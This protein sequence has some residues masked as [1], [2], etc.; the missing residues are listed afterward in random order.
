MDDAGLPEDVFTSG[1]TAEERGRL[2]GTSLRVYQYFAGLPEPLRVPDFLG[3][4]RSQGLS[5]PFPLPVGPFLLAPI[6]HRGEGVGNIYLA[7]EE[8][9]PEFSRED[10]ET[11]VLFASQAALV[12]ANARRH[13]DERRARADLEA[14][15]NT[16]PV[17]VLVF[18][19]LTGNPVSVNQEARRIIGDLH[20]PHR[21]AEELLDDLTVRRDDGREFS[22]QELSVAQ[23]L[24]AAVTV[25]AE[26]IVLTAPDGRSVTALINA[27]PIRGE[28]GAVETCVVTLQDMTPLEE[29]ERLRAEFLAMVSHELRTPLA[30]VKGSVANLLDP[31][32]SLS[33]AEALQFFRIID[34][35]T[36][37]MRSLI[38]DLLDVARIETGTLSVSPEPTELAVLA[39]EAADAFRVGGHK[40]SLRIDLQPDLPWVMADRSRVV[41]V[42]GNLLSNAARHSP[43]SSA[44]LVTAV[45]QELHVAVSVSDDGRGIAAESLPLLFRK[46]SRIEGEEQDGDTGLGLAVCKGIVE[47]HGG[48]IWADSD[49]PGRGASFTFTLPTAGEGGYV[50]PAPPVLISGRI[51]RQRGAGEQVRILSLDDDPQA[52]RYIRDSL[53]KAGYAVIATDDADDVPRLMEVEKPHVVLLDLML[54][55]ADGIELT[56][57][58]RETSSTPVIFVS[59]YG[60]DQL[61]AR[62]LEAGGDDYVVKPFSPTELVARIRAVLRRRETP[63]PT[64]PYVFGDLTVDYAARL[65]TF[66]GSPVRLTSM[67]YR[68]LAELS[69]NAG[70]VVT[71]AHLLERVWEAEAGADL[72]PM[73]T[74]I[75]TLR[76]NMGDDADNPAYIFT[77]PRVGYRMPKGAESREKTP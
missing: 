52:L 72:R 59:A 2:A 27:T 48:R 38:S 12:I 57:K 53:V 1:I 64:V 62:A 44:V 30:T 33:R 45:R 26:E 50:L 60:R 34:S 39:G 71:Y 17:G 7:R 55:G 40:Q 24:S 63:V 56:K 51:A 46:F 13:R 37:R 25:R 31:A 4:A 66:A 70:R 14:L 73:R 6:R 32:A 75:S 47:A 43:E 16:A 69:T 23:A 3:H 20:A 49:G 61:I 28:D 77:E 58:I 41:Q 29:L 9:G 10:E 74:V 8:G 42:L 36:D 54:Q 18:D 22:L 21:R 35:Q 15:V 19:A 11:L 76:R 68:T 67:E 5:A 65:V